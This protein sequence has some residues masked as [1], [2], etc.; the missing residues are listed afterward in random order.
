MESLEWRVGAIPMS[1][2]FPVFFFP[3]FDSLPSLGDG[4]GGRIL[5]R[6]R[7]VTGGDRDGVG[8][9]VMGLTGSGWEVPTAIARYLP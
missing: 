9:G 3:Q 5:W 4:G 8:G 2:Y 7:Q 6:R 1:P